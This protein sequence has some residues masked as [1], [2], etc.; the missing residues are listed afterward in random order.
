MAKRH[1]PAT[2]RN[3]E[4]ILA[5]L[6]EELG[7][8]GTLLEI[9]A[10]SGEHAVFF[11]NGLPDWQWQPT[12]PDPEAVASIAAYRAEEGGPNL[13]PPV[14]LDAALPNWP[15]EAPDAVLC[16]NMVHISPWSATRG[17]MRECG[18]LLPKGAPLIL[19][20]P[21]IED[22][23]PTAPSN[24]DFDLSLKSR[25]ERWGL[26]NVADMD[27]EAATHGLKRT[28]RVVMPAN[29]LVLVYRKS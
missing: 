23:V 4:P 27:V 15:V 25:D 11:A 24:R 18:R 26:R 8:G 17:L 6:R 1:A 10:G 2:L 21:Y 5:V 28:R 9:A 7:E 22:D 3:R 19:Y 20:G 29:N 16:I 13:L 12:D 14:Q